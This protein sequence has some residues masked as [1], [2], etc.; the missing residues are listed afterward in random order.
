MD[1]DNPFGIFKLFCQHGVDIFRKLFEGQ[2]ET[3]L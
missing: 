1:F 3:I 2:D